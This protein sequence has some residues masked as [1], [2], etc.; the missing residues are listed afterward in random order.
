MALQAGSDRRAAGPGRRRPRGHPNA[1]G[2]GAAS[3]GDGRSPRRRA[4]R[5]G[6]YLS[7]VARR[8]RPQPGRLVCD[9]RGPIPGDRPRVRS[10]LPP[11]DLLPRAAA[12]RLGLGRR[13]LHL[14]AHGF[15]GS[16]FV[17]S[18]VGN[19]ARAI[20]PLRPVSPRPGG[21]DARSRAVRRRARDRNHQPRPR[22]NAR[23]VRQVRR[24]GAVRA[25]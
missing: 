20:S 15:C 1:D 5:R 17:Q 6:Q 9:Q 2:N 25:R 12:V 7:R 14:A 23:G 19:V 18:R 3:D 24:R 10:V 13:R 4:S 21:G 8:A 16:A 11:P 22:R